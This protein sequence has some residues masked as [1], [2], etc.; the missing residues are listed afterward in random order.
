MTTCLSAVGLSLLL[1]TPLLELHTTHVHDSGGDLVHVV[2]L[3]LGEAQDVESFLYRQKRFSNK[4]F[5]FSAAITLS[6]KQFS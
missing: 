5:L 1:A 3:F 2:L 4:F 6:G